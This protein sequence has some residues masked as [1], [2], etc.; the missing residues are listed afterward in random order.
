MAK[1]DKQFNYCNVLNRLLFKNALNSTKVLDCV[2][3]L[4]AQNLRTTPLPH[5]I[6]IAIVLVLFLAGFR[7]FIG[8][9]INQP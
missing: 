3:K 2:K 6:P 1:N 9:T 4:Q 7:V 8:I 5:P